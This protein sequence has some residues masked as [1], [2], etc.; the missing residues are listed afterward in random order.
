M[1]IASREFSKCSEYDI[2]SYHQPKLE[3]PELFF[4]SFFYLCG[5]QSIQNSQKVILPIAPYKT[6]L[7]INFWITADIS[8]SL[9]LPLNCSFLG[10]DQPR[11]S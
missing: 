7:G 2:F 1:Q 11:Q 10:K 5:L 9:K 4:E 3:I 6:N 8:I